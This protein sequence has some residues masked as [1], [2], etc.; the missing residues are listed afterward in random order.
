MPA[1][2]F[3][4]VHAADLHL[5]QPLAG[6]SDVPDHL[7]KPLVDA[8]YTAAERV[9][10]SVLAENADFLVLAGNVLNVHQA[11]PR[12]VVFLLDQFE[13]LAAR[14]VAVYWAGGAEDP[15]EAW[16]AA[17]KLPPNVHVFARGEVEALTHSRHE[18]PLCRVAG[19]S[20]DSGVLRPSDFQTDENGL[21]TIAVAHGRTDAAALAERQIDYWALGGIH[22]RRSLSISQGT[23]HYCGSPQGRSP[24]EAGPHGCTLASIDLE[25]KVRTQ[26]ITTDVLRWHVE[27]LAI[28]EKASPDDLQRLLAERM[29]ALASEARDRGALVN[30]TIE[31]IGLPIW[32][33]GQPAL[34][35]ELLDRLRAEFGTGDAP[36]WT[37]SLEFEPPTALPPAWC[38]EDTIL[39]DFLRAVRVHEADDRQPLDVAVYLSAGQRDGELAAA[40]ELADP[41]AR[42]RALRDAAALGIELLRGEA[43]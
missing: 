6:L 8:P 28:A 16:P 41:V 14:D 4:F 5:E 12:A 35:A 30:W 10:D 27:R 29:R 13:R 34:A 21:F 26:F 39:G 40:L 19:T 23:A 7:R 43:T 11:G 31:Q 24:A 3:R 20:C 9:F 17:A 25:G 32:K 42:R 36:V 1:E 2:P 37:G 22:E 38:E 15:P 18:E 33:S